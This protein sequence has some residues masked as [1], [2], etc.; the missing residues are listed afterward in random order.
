MSQYF[1]K[2]FRSFGRN[3]NPIQDPGGGGGQ[4]A[5]PTSFY[6]V[7]STNVGISP[8]NFPTFSFDP[9]DILA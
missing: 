6:P 3:I 4:K 9:F 8:K 1:H 2:P 7:T 5:P